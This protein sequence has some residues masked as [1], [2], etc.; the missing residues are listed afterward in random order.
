MATHSS[1]SCLENLMDRGAWRATGYGVAKSRIGLKRL[2]TQAHPSFPTG[3]GC[4]GLTH[5]PLH[6]SAPQF[7][8]DKN[9][10][11]RLHPIPVPVCPTE[12][13][14]KASSNAVY[15]LVSEVLKTEYIFEWELF[16]CV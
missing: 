2:S 12:L 3:E 11:N 15:S 5:P 8:E 7:P 6:L 16:K 1:I 4:S 13:K 14:N 9:C 10:S